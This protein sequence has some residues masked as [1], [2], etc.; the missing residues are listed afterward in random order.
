MP[1]SLKKSLWLLSLPL[2]VMLLSG[3]TIPGTDI[4][5]PGLP[6]FFGST[7][8]EY[9]NDILVIKSLQAIPA[10]VSPGQTV[11]IIATIQNKGTQRIPMSELNVELYDYCPGLFSITKPMELPKGDLYPEQMIQLTWRLKASNDVAVESVCPSDGMKLAVWYPHETEAIATIAFID[12]AEKNRLIQE[13]KYGQTSSQVTV[14]EGPVKPYIE[15]RDSQPI[16]SNSGT[17]NIVFQVRNRGNG[18]IKRDQNDPINPVV[19]WVLVGSSDSTMA[20]DL[21]ACRKE[22]EGKFVLIGGKSAELPCIITVPK[23]QKT[24]YTETITT[25]ISYW[26]EFRKNVIVKVKPKS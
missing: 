9:E 21:E 6:D 7:T 16:A 3:C 19:S 13:G 2:V 20:R 8:V 22:H 15:I 23:K 18:F 24:E 11:T 25:K 5:I 4:E 1:N 10:E 26:Y 17:T 14:G 12:E